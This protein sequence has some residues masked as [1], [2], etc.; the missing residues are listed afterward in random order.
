MLFALKIIFPEGRENNNK[1][2]KPIVGCEC[3]QSF[4]L[5]LGF[6]FIGAS[7]VYTSNL[8]RYT[9]FSPIYFLHP[10]AARYDAGWNFILMEALILFVLT[11][12]PTVI[13]GK[14]NEI[15]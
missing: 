9:E 1:I 3:L 12:V 15:Y 6:N 7:I 8:I 14:G 4:F 11:F 13:K 5:L 2:K 10:A